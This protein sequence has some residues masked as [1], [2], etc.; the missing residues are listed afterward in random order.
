MEGN[1]NHV[2]SNQS[3]IHPDLKQTVLKHLENPYKAPIRG[4]S[5]QIVEYM[6]TQIN[7]HSDPIILD[8]GC[9][10]GE[11]TVKLS[12]MY[13]DALVIGIDKSIERINETPWDNKRQTTERYCIIRADLIDI[14]R[15][16]ADNGIKL[17]H[18]FIL[19]PNPWPKKKHL[20]RRWHG[21]PVFPHLLKLGG[22]IHLRTNWNTYAREFQY[23]LELA[24]S[25][26][27]EVRDFTA[28]SPLSPFERKYSQS[29]HTLFELTATPCEVTTTP[30]LHEAY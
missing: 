11:S 24:G 27:A 26:Q 6:L 29:N 21:H 19:Y 30:D 5:M 2:T 10:T 12:R 18:H 22:T 8:S 25:H 15:A 1:S 17:Q 13:P 20:M 3:G 28:K 4:F 16:L 14:W 9:G 7:E 23:A